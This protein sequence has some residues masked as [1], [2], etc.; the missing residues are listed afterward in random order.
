MSSSSPSNYNT[1]ETHTSW[2]QAKAGWGRGLNPDPAKTINSVGTPHLRECST[3]FG[4]RGILTAR[5]IM[6]GIVNATCG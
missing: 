6:L 3:P 4:N 2:G 5:T 1:I